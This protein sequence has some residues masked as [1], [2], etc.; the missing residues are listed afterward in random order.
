M[1][2]KA[3]APGTKKAAASKPA[4]KKQKSGDALP[5]D[6]GQPVDQSVGRRGHWKEGGL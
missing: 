4:E 1:T 5:K 6:N 2:K 3:A